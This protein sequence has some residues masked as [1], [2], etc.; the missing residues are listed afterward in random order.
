VSDS[1]RRVAVVGAGMSGVA[2]AHFLKRAGYQPE[3][4]ETG[5]SLGG[6][7]GS[8]ELGDRSIDI[9]GKNIGRKYRLF[10]EFLAEHGAPSLEF[11]GINSST[12][13]DGRLYTVDSRKKLASLW[14]VLRLVG[15]R[16]FWRLFRLSSIVR[17]DPAEGLLGGPRFSQLSEQRD[18]L[19]LAA[20]FGER[21]TQT[22]LRPITL[23]MNGAEPDAYFLGCLGSNLKMVFDSYDQLSRGMG[24]LLQSFAKAVPV[25]L[26]TR[27]VRLLRS[28]ARVIGVETERGGQREQRLY[29]SVVL[30]LPAPASA[31]LLLGE[32][33]QEA[34]KNV[35]YNPV[36]LLVARYR[37]PIFDSKVRAIVFDAQSPLSNAGCYGVND[38]DLVRYTLSGRAAADIDDASEPSEVLERA[39]RELGRFVKVR[40]SER[41]GYVSKHFRHGLCAY[42]PYHHRFIGRCLEWERGVPGLVLT[43]DYLRGASIEACFQAAFDGVER[44]KRRAAE[45]PRSVP[46]H[47]S[48]LQ[49]NVSR[50]PRAEAV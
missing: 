40:A 28:G 12:V 27:V 39:E 30:A 16:D 43:G 38:L 34:L 8:L 45:S 14:H 36:T 4:F 17:E 7:A 48:P 42:G 11:F 33:I 5:S 41:I 9:G 44:L 25:S 13:R 3:I 15:P 47:A 26:N 6:R 35:A 10:R 2:T 24:P 32:P 23:R 1:A 31:R 50:E 19:P 22:F 46:S 29:P 49:S 18:H 37:R 20:W 21:A